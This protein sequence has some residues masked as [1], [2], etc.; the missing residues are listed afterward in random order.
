M[1]LVLGLTGCMSANPM[2]WMSSEKPANPPS[3]LGEQTN[4][5]HPK[6]LWQ[7]NIGGGSDR[8]LLKL[9]P[10]IVAGRIYLA[11]ASGTVEAKDAANGRSLWRVDTKTPISAG[12]G[13][14]EGLVLVGTR[15]AH[16]LALDA[17]NGQ[18][19][20]K[21]RVSSEVLAVP[22]IGMGVVVAHTLDGK[23]T[24]LDAD[25][26]TQRWSYE[27]EVPV[28]SLRGSS[29]PVIM[30]ASVIAGFA[31]GKLA[32]I[33][34]SSGSLNWE[35][36]LG[37]SS[38]RTE[39]DRMTDIDADPLVIGNTIYAVTYQGD[40]AAVS[41]TDGSVLWRRKLSSY[42]GLGG[43]DT[44]L[45]VTDD[46]DQVWAFDKGSSNSLWKQSN[47]LYRRLTAPIPFN[48]YV[49]AGDFEGYLHWF[50]PED[51]SIVARTRL[52][53]SPITAT[54]QVVDGRLYV[55]SDGGDFAAIGL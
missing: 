18:Q 50:K 21:V 25:S 42:S 11:N 15:D 30:G 3:V 22:R 36:S 16:I 40:L 31:N 26:G 7:A 23:L 10:A 33:N 13:A 47:L 17:N 48:G 9:E 37:I 6:T 46:K 27:H 20:W 41:G 28:L 45:Y 44:Q 35:V 53:S 55:Y 24:G 19:R 51:G 12:P 39:L 2:N 8:K 29:S 32:S 1:A 14:G 54:P 43:G 4:R 49:V 34:L 38:G 5:I 52:G